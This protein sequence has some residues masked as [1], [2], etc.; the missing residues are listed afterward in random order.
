MEKTHNKLFTDQETKC[1][2]ICEKVFRVILKKISCMPTG[3][4]KL[5]TENAE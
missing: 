2:L 1:S 3:W 4:I 5:K